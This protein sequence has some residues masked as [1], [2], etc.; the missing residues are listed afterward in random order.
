MGGSATLGSNLIDDLVPVVDDLRRDLYDSMG[1]TQFV[2]NRVKRTWSGSE[3]SEGTV[4]V[5]FRT[6]LDP[7]PLLKP[8]TEQWKLEA[9]GRDEQGTVR[10]EGVSLTYT[11]AELT[12][13]TLAANEEFFYEMVETRGQSITTRHFVLKDKP[14]TDREKTIGWV[15]LLE[16]CEVNQP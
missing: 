13:G 2:V 4:T 15:V 5:N 16:R 1:I 9:Q 10:L 7:T 3:R 14:M 6:A 11:E 12:G 8:V